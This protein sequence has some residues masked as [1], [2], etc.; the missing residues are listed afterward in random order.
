MN[1][2]IFEIVMVVLQL[3]LFIPFYLVWRKDRKEIGEDLAVSLL[4]R[5][6]SYIVFIPLWLIP[7]F[8]A[9]RCWQWLSISRGSMQ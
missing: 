5:F 8:C 3:L 6:M 7:I 2:W 4:E 9:V 1:F